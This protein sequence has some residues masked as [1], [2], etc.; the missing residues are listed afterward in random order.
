MALQPGTT[1]GSY[2]V[3]AKIG[4]GGMGEEVGDTSIHPFG[5]PAFQ[6]RV[7]FR[8]IVLEGDFHD[9]PQAKSSVS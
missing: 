3:T 8:L 4:E 7:R 5:V 9:C 1:L 2:S 6:H